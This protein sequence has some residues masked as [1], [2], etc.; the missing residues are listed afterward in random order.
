MVPSESFDREASK[1]TRNG[2][3]PVVALAFSAALGGLLAATSTL[4]RTAVD[5]APSSS[6]TTRLAM[7]FPTVM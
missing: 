6:V 7:N 2:A 3:F 5:G 1:V 4:V